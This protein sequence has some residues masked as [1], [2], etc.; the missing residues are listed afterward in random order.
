MTYRSLQFLKEQAVCT[1][2]LP[3]VAFDFHRPELEAF[4]IWELSTNVTRSEMLIKAKAAIPVHLHPS[5]VSRCAISAQPSREMCSIV[6]SR[7]VSFR[8]NNS[9]FS[10]IWRILATSPCE[11]HLVMFKCKIL[12]SHR[13]KLFFSGFAAHVVSV[14]LLLAALRSNIA[15]A[16][17]GSLLR[18]R[19]PM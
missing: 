16:D 9:D 1:T 8:Q 4:C 7:H 2:R 14:R 3:S 6:R 11:I 18:K 19:G 10:G 17:L 13:S 5:A 12:I 15:T